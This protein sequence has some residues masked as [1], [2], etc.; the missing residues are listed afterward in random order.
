MP[1]ND[2]LP[3]AIGTK[4]IHV[5]AEL[6]VSAMH[7]QDI[8]CVAQLMERAATHID[9]LENLVSELK[10]KEKIAS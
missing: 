5:S 6:R 8:G 7:L 3:T 9:A 1:L 10:A 4:G 2:L